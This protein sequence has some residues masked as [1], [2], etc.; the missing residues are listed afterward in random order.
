MELRESKQNTVSP[1]GV[2]VF[3]GRLRKFLRLL[4]VQGLR[5]SDWGIK[6]VVGIV[7]ADVVDVVVVL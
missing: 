4:G 7:V 3:E 1:R 5:L 6:G 2:V